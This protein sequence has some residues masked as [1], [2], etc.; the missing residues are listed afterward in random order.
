MAWVGA[1]GRIS[2]RKSADDITR[3]Y[4]YCQRY[5]LRTFC[6]H[7]ASYPAHG[8]SQQ[9]VKQV[10]CVRWWPRSS[11]FCSLTANTHRWFDPLAKF[12]GIAG[13]MS[14]VSSAATKSSC[15]GPSRARWLELGHEDRAVEI[16]INHNGVD[17]FVID[18]DQDLEQ[19]SADRSLSRLMDWLMDVCAVFW[20]SGSM[21]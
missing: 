12:I 21:N 20:K 17:A 6:M 11:K 8:S 18:F 15:T 16:H 7:S 14:T 9:H 4:P 5:R 13:R 10:Y 2:V 3:G 1:V 19:N